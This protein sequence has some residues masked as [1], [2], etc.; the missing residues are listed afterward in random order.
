MLRVVLFSCL[1]L[2]GLVIEIN[3]KILDILCCKDTNSRNLAF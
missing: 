2:L 1:P 3:D